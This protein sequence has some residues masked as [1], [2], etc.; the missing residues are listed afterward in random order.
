M[1]TSKVDG[2][3]LWNNETG[4]GLGVFVFEILFGMRPGDD[5][6]GGVGVEPADFGGDSSTFFAAPIEKGDNMDA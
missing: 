4:V 6:P 3:G 2:V 5:L 1:E